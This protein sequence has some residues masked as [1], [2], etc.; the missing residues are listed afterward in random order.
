MREYIK[1]L[2]V[3][4]MV[5]ALVFGQMGACPVQGATK[6]PK[7]L[8]LSKSKLTMYVGQKETISVDK[9]TPKNASK[10]VTFTSLDTKIATVNPREKLRQKK[11]EQ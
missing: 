7:S 10:K 5:Y 11:M 2:T 9:V 4:I 6:A 3:M 8:T 1:R